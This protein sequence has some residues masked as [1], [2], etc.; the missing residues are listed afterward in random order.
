MGRAGK[1]VAVTGSGR[2]SR[3]GKHAAVVG[4]WPSLRQ[5]V[6]TV[7]AA[8]WVVGCLVALRETA[9]A[10]SAASGAVTVSSD[11]SP[12]ARVTV[13]G[14]ERLVVYGHSMPAGG[15][16]S[17]ASLSYATRAAEESGLVL[18]NRAV[19]GSSAAA[20]AR[21]MAAA[22]PAT[23][24]DAVVIHTGMNDIFR[25]GAGAVRHGRESIRQLLEGTSEARRR[26]VVLECQPASWRITPPAHNL[27]AAYEAWNRMLRQEASRW[28]DVGVLDTCESWDPTQFLDRREYHPNDRGHELIADA[29]VGA[30]AGP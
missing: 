2:L 22:R 21:S 16:A 9:P 20:A 8:L 26:T 7:A 30:L 24:R 15:G 13:A 12:V 28:P 29:L 11:S 3:T 25:H 4:P 6:W 1:H 19:G 5:L 23:W 14:L 18:V 27:Q 17:R 10:A